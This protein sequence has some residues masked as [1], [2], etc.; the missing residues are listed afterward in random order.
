[1]AADLVEGGALRSDE[2]PHRNDIFIVRPAVLI[3]TP[4]AEVRAT[5]QDTRWAIGAHGQTKL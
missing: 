3:G 2:V 1:V 4:N 5:E